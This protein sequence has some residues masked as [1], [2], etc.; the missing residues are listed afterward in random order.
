MPMVVL[1][2]LYCTQ[3]TVKHSIY[4][5]MTLIKIPAKKH[6]KAFIRLWS[7]GKYSEPCPKEKNSTSSEGT[8]KSPKKETDPKTENHEA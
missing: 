4:V 2:N 5:F 1:S 7:Y 6:R 8:E 3:F